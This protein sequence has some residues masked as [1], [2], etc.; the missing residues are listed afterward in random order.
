[1]CEMISSSDCYHVAEL[2]KCAENVLSMEFYCS[3]SDNKPAEL[4]CRIFGLPSIGKNEVEILANR[5]NAAIKAT[6]EET[7]TALQELAKVRF[8]KDA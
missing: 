2:M 1:M 3:K 6:K 4:D 7:A 8:T 5:L